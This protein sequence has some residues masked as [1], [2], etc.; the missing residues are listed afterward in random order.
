MG[1]L[2]AGKVVMVTG[3][4]SGIGRAAAIVFA[5]QGAKV[6]VTDIDP[7][8]AVT[9]ERIRQADGIAEFVLT[10]VSDQ[11]QVEAAVAFAAKTYGRLDGAFNNAA[12]PERLT[13]LLE[14]T[15]ADF[16]RIMSIN[17][18]GLWMCMRAQI[19]QMQAQGGGGSIVNTASTAGLRG[20]ARMSIY[21]ASKHAVIGFTKSAALEFARTGPRINAICP[22]VI[23]TPMLRHVVAGDERAHRAFLASQPN[24]RLGNPDEIG[25]AAAWLLS[26]AASFVTGTA[27]IVDGGQTS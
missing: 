16:D 18:K 5:H 27:M 17:V 8:G 24:G 20:S 11:A 6:V 7:H 10:D 13:R 4:A 9:V 3:A 26:D 12:V 23:E 21:S 25:Q 2:L 14:G 22:G 15:E 19:R 1:G